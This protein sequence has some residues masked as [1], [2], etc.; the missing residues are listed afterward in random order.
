MRYD[1]LS[2]QNKGIPGMTRTCDPRFRKPKYPT[3]TSVN[4]DGHLAYVSASAIVP[5]VRDLNAK[6]CLEN[7]AVS[8]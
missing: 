8:P 3:C 5:S 2:R 4:D 6:K 1:T 7:R